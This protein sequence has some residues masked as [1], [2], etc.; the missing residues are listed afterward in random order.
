MKP[1]INMNIYYNTWTHMRISI[2]SRALLKKDNTREDKKKKKVKA[3]IMNVFEVIES[4]YIY[5]IYIHMKYL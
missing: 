1:I 3:N 5:H 4:I 2:D